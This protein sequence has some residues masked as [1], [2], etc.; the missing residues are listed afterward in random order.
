MGTT[1]SGHPAANDYDDPRL[2]TGE[3]PGNA[4]GV[5]L[6]VFKGCLPLFLHCAARLDREVEPLRKR[7][8]W[9]IGVR[10]ARMG[11]TTSDHAGWAMDCWADGIGAH[12]WPPR[13][14]QAKAAKMLAVVSSYRTPDGRRIFGW[15]AHES[16]GGDYRKQAS[17]DPMHV[18]VRP[19]ITEADVAACAKRLG[20]KAD[21]TEAP[22]RTAGRI[23]VTGS[24][25]LSARQIADRL[26]IGVRHV[27]VRNAWLL[28]R[29]ARRGD[30]V[31]VPSWAPVVRLDSTGF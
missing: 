21:G 15:G 19:G 1:I 24:G 20:I 14:S 3:V 6:T 27:L 9:S 2:D 25:R 10:Q 8:T 12:T 5:K 17:N 22:T 16:L 29:R 26:G 30:M 28:T 18:F 4:E 31:R 23:K 11:S 13:M 7:D